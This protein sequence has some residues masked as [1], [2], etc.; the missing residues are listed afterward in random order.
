MQDLAL[1]DHIFIFNFIP[2]LLCFGISLGVH[3]HDTDFGPSVTLVNVFLSYMFQRS[4]SVNW[5]EYKTST[6]NYKYFVHYY[7]TP[8]S[9]KFRLSKNIYLFTYL[10]NYFSFQGTR[11][12]LHPCWTS[13]G[14]VGAKHLRFPQSL[15]K[16]RGL[17]VLSLSP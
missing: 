3:F 11:H 7:L 5:P 10:D 13:T 6:A 14:Y 4:T 12:W 17:M 2:I 9:N 16:R 1:L 15:F 8:F